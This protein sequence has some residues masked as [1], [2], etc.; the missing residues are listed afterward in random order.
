MFARQES[1]VPPVQSDK[2][3]DTGAAETMEKSVVKKGMAKSR[4]M[5]K[6]EKANKK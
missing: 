4:I 2:D 3:G 1:K 6:D 5:G